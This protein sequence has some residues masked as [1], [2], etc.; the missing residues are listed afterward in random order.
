MA[1]RGQRG[2][3]YSKKRDL[4]AQ[5]KQGQPMS[6]FA[7]AL[8]KNHGSIHYAVSLHGG[9]APVERRRSRL[10]LSLPERE[11]ISRGI[12][13]GH[14]LRHIAST[15]Q[16]APSSRADAR[17]T[18][19]HGRDRNGPASH[20]AALRIGI[21]DTRRFDRG[22]LAERD[23]AHRP[24]PGDRSIPLARGARDG[25]TA[26]AMT[27]CLAVCSQNQSAALIFTFPRRSGW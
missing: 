22:A 18:H 11:E 24:R 9:I 19:R 15:I 5:W 13:T 23:D 7:R 4:W 2:L 8:E 27:R 14:S 25:S 6:E 20:D 26:A 16:R 10:A 21:I 1:Q 3:S 12:A 17:G